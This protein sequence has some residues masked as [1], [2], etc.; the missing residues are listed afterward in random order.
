MKVKCS[1]DS[2]REDFGVDVIVTTKFILEK[3]S[4]KNS[5]LTFISLLIEYLIRHVLHRK[6]CVQQFLYCCV[7]I[8]YL[9]T[10][11]L[12]SLCLEM[13]GE[14]DTQTNKEQGNLISLISIFQNKES[15]LKWI[16]W[17]MLCSVTLI[18]SSAYAASSNRISQ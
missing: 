16:N 18:N 12:R 9:G 8:C 6:H 17:F 14:G 3:S 5:R 10:K 1:L 13:T 11:Y 15:G 4:G 7:C 2:H